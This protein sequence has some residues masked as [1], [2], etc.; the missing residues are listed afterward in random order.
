MTNFGFII[1]NRRCIGCHACTVACKSEHEVAVGV[2]R[3]WVKYIEKGE[4]PQSRRLFSV[5]RCNHCD[6]APCVE[7]CPVTALFQ[8]DDGIVD[9]DNR[10]CIG[11]KACMQACPYDA[12]YIDP[13]T[14]TAAKCNYCA[15]RIDIGLEPACVNVCPTQAI[16]SGDLDDPNSRISQLKSREVVTVRKPE[17]ATQ[18]ALFYIDGD[19]ASLEPAATEPIGQSMWGQQTAGVGHYASYLEKRVAA[20]AGTN[21]SQQNQNGAPPNDDKHPLDQLHGLL[22]LGERSDGVLNPRPGD[23]KHIDSTKAVEKELA[24]RAYDAP[25]KGVLWGWQVS[26]YVWTKAIAA[27]VGLVASAAAL[28]GFA[29]VTPAV[30]WLT[31][32]VALVFM[33]VTGYLLTIDL[34]QPK[35]FLYVIL[36]PQWRSWLVRGAYIISIYSAL[37]VMWPF[38]VLFN[39]AQISKWFWGP[40]AVFSGLTAVYTAFLFAQAKGRDFWQSPLLSVHMLLHSGIAGAAIFAI[41]LPLLNDTSWQAFIPK[42]LMGLLV[43]KL[44]VDWFELASTHAT[45]DAKKTV[46]QITQGSFARMYWLGVIL[47]GCLVPIVA[48]ATLPSFVTPICGVLSLIGLYLAE[49][50]WVRAP[51][52]IP[53]S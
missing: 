24:R 41:T 48:L 22:D 27:G 20:K 47:V 5:M 32:A 19:R 18:P 50:I 17:K 38:L 3:T 36:R 13:N 34:D 44:I 46:H 28:G 40:L 35:R 10:R 25:S 39:D 37:L 45:A 4:F 43:T 16:I 51:Q 52:Q 31:I 15:H 42:V 2:N 53:L 6:D 12:L 30:Q 33:A 23:K 29:T 7:I 14:H 49:H 26:A 9:F 1:D 8:R 21:G 11:C